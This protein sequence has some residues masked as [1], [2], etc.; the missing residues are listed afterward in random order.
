M[1]DEGKAKANERDRNAF[2]IFNGEGKDAS[3]PLIPSEKSEE[4]PLQA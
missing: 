3:S 1:G 4:I 2:E